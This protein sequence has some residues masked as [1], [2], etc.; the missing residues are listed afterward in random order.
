MENITVIPRISRLR[1]R[2]YFEKEK[3]EYKFIDA[4]DFPDGTPGGCH[5]RGET[6]I[7]SG[8]V[9]GVVSDLSTKE[10]YDILYEIVPGA[11]KYREEDKT[12]SF[13]NN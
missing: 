1:L 9:K 2:D 13:K 8:E 10:I 11:E 12:F 7:G 3:I 5:F 6:F 4:C